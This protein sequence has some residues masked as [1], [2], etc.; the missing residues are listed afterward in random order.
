M[1]DRQVRPQQKKKKKN[2]FA[3]ETTYREEKQAKQERKLF[4]NSISDT[5]LPKHI[6]NSYNSLAK[7]E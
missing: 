3:Q 2:V 5:F 4:I 6:R 7:T 1:K